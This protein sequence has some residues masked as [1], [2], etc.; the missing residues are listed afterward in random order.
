MPRPDTVAVLAEAFSEYRQ[1]LT[2]GEIQDHLA[3]I[4][5][6]SVRLIVFRGA[7]PRTRTT[8]TH[9]LAKNQG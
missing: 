7:F 4:Y 6:T 5:D 3:E 9:R 8:P 2:T 1:G